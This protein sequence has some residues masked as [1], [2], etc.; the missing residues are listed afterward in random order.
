MYGPRADLQTVEFF[1]VFFLQFFFR[2]RFFPIFITIF[3]STAFKNISMYSIAGYLIFTKKESTEQSLF[4]SC[5]ELDICLHFP[6]NV[7][8]LFNDKVI[9]S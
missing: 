7:H 8:V 5:S 6:C 9:S 3:K 2:D 4:Y 1:I